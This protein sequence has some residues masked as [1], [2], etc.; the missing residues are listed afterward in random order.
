V[1][2]YIGYC[3]QHDALLDKLTVREHLEL[4]ARI[5]GVPLA[6]MKNYCHGMMK[7]LDL[8][9]H[10]DKTSMTLSGG[11]KRKLSMAIAFMGAPPLIFLDEPSTGVDPAARRLMWNV[12]SAVSTTRR[13]CSVILTTHNMEEAEALC[14][15]IGIMVGGRLRCIGSNQHLKARFGGGYQ[16]ETRLR[17]ADS[18]WLT[19]F[20]ADRGIPEIIPVSAVVDLC[21][22]LGAPG[23]ANLVR[24]DCEAGHAIYE[25]V[26]REGQVDSLLFADWWL[27]EDRVDNLTVFLQQNF[28]GTTSIERHDRTLRFS[29][30]RDLKL[31]DVFRKLEDARV[32]LHLEEYGISQMSLEQIFNQLA[33]QQ[34]EETGA[35]RGF[36]TAADVLPT[37]VSVTSHAISL[38]VRPEEPDSE[39][40]PE[41][42]IKV[43]PELPLL[44]PSGSLTA[45]S[46]V[47]FKTAPS[48]SASMTAAGANAAGSFGVSPPAASA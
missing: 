22:R 28:P 21:Q 15:S 10:V 47:S 18:T 5:K 48:G 31:A 34:T 36:A 35:V 6:V 9:E 23:R 19:G 39:P 44:Q 30:P 42:S 2:R 41:I 38:Q 27:L 32:Q 26:A 37:E 16:L 40:A 4:F 45:P 29:L 8:L 11:N 33:A 14:S 20:C 46:D 17:R 25:M 13:E 3:P 43:A 24:P 12:I 7:E 1:R